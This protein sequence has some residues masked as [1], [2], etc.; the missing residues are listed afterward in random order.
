MLEEICSLY[1]YQKQKSTR[2][3][4]EVFQSK[5]NIGIK[6]NGYQVPVDKFPAIRTQ[7]FQYTI[8]VGVMVSKWHRSS[9][10]K[11][12]TFTSVQL[13]VRKFFYASS[14][15]LQAMN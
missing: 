10:L 8:P 6:A 15:F 2:E 11:Q 14:S 9:Q 7:C 4:Q 12:R 3:G 13:C 1:K 5:H